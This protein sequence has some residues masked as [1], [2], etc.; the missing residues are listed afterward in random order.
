MRP[1]IW[2]KIPLGLRYHFAGS[3][4]MVASHI[5]PYRHIQTIYIH[6]LY[7]P[8]ATTTC[9]PD[10]PRGAPKSCVIMLGAFI[11]GHKISNTNDHGRGNEGGNP[12]KETTAG[13]EA[14]ISYHW[15]IT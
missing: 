11:N 13:Y 7:F 5:V 14:S 9:T 15:I 1:H 12:P 3:D 8:T 4:K 2:F 10:A 6:Q